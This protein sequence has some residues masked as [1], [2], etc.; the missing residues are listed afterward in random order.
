MNR[1]EQ[2]SKNGARLKMAFKINAIREKNDV[3][4]D[5]SELLWHILSDKPGYFFRSFFFSL[6]SFSITTWG[7]FRDI[8]KYY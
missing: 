1:S 6:F 7:G 2:A 5:L 3:T 8:T 4:K